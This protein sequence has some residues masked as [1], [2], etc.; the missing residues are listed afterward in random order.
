MKKFRQGQTWSRNSEEKKNAS[1][2]QKLAQ[3]L[4][5]SIFKYVPISPYDISSAQW[6]RDYKSK[7]CVNPAKLREFP[8]DDTDYPFSLSQPPFRNLYCSN[9][10]WKEPKLLN[11]ITNPPCCLPWKL[12]TSQEWNQFVAFINFRNVE[13]SNHLNGQPLKIVYALPTKEEFKMLLINEWL[14]QE[15]KYLTVH[16]SDNSTNVVYFLNPETGS[17]ETFYPHYI[18]DQLKWLVSS[19]LPDEEIRQEISKLLDETSSEID[20]DLTYTILNLANRY[21]RQDLID[22]PKLMKIVKKYHDEDE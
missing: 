5:H 18:M 1:H 7:T 21:H 13:F 12:E 16:F 8:I 4:K 20:E 10:P 3:V 9:H 19:D 15:F 6:S 17:Y 11:E 14:S 22:Y 2:Y